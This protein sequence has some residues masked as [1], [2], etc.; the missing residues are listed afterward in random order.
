MRAVSLAHTRALPLTRDAR[1]PQSSAT[2]QT[3]RDFRSRRECECKKTKLI[4]LSIWLF[5]DQSAKVN[6][7]L[8]SYIFPQ[9]RVYTW[10]NDRFLFRFC[11][12]TRARNQ[13]LGGASLLPP[14]WRL[15]KTP[16]SSFLFMFSF[17]SFQFSHTIWDQVLFTF[18]FICFSLVWIFARLF[19]S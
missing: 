9:R 16:L 2:S 15:C 8:I 13:R 11:Q 5:C 1:P 6:M 14:E 4:T 3:L 10:V 18:S 12:I 7:R 17:N 19:I